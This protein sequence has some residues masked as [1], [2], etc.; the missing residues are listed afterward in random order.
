MTAGT[1]S[2][3]S[4]LDQN[5]VANPRNS[6]NINDSVNDELFIDPMMGAPLTIYI[7]KDV[8]DKDILADLIV[9][10]RVNFSCRIS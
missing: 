5:A 1:S 10:S 2:R 9:V 6:E 8:I 4:H 7:E 3:R